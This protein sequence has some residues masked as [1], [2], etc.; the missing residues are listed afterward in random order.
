MDR[1]KVNILLILFLFLF[2]NVS[3]AGF[4][5]NGTSEYVDL[6][7]NA[8]T[9]VI[10]DFTISIWFRRDTEWNSS[11][12]PDESLVS[13]GQ[14]AGTGSWI[15]FWSA[16]DSGQMRA[17]GSFGGFVGTTT[18][19]WTAGKIYNV[20]SVIDATNDIDVWVN[21]VREQFQDTV[22]DTFDASA[23]VFRL[24]YDGGSGQAF[25]GEILGFSMWNKVLTDEQVQLNYASG[26]KNIPLQIEP[27]N[28]VISLP[29]NDV[30]D[31]QS[32]DGATFR[33][34]SSN[35]YHGTAS[36]GT[37]QADEFF[38]Y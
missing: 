2:T 29:L 28:L 11:S 3:S 4:K 32:A 17:P 7:D 31:G 25:A 23:F 21:G 14:L 36:G 1:I 24:G 18:T 12:T 6:P 20:T 33:D 37:G 34:I 26:L 10:D 27:N 15:F 16:A 30:A 22:S 9:R 13:K 38:S 35:G 8:D 5:G 19:T